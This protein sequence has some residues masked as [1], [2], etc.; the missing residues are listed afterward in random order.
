MF[1]HFYRRQTM[2]SNFVYLEGRVIRG[3]TQFTKTGKSISKATIV[4]GGGKDKPGTFVDIEI[5]NAKEKFITALGKAAE[6]KNVVLI[7]KG[8]LRMDQWETKEGQKRSKIKVVA[9]S[10]QLTVREPRKTTDEE[11]QPVQPKKRAAKATGPV[12]V[13]RPAPQDEEEEADIAV[14]LDDDDDDMPF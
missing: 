12:K 11:E 5:W 2:S 8:S 13:K 7:V 3:T 1:Y 14:E 6:L 4:M 9:D 10:Y